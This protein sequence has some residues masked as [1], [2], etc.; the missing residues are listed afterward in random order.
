MRDDDGAADDEADGEGLEEFLVGEPSSTQR[1]TVG[2]AAVAAEDEE[3]TRPRVLVS[4][5]APS[6]DA[7]IEGEEAADLEVVGPR[8]RSFMRS[9]NLRNSSRFIVRL[10]DREDEIGFTVLRRKTVQ[11]NRSLRH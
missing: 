3:A 5:S 9:R 8:M 6:V 4:G 11:W 2:D 1:M 10:L 7:G